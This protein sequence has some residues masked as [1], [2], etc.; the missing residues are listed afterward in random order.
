MVDNSFSQHISLPQSRDNQ[1]TQITQT[2][3]NWVPLLL[4][5]WGQ[6]DV[7]Y[8]QAYILELWGQQLDCSCEVLGCTSGL[9]R[10]RRPVLGTS[11]LFFR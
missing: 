7:Q 10:T 9:T 11:W 8:L 4:A 2:L 6:N 3:K 1:Q 5:L